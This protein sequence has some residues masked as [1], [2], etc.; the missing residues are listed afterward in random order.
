M[1]VVKLFFTTNAAAS[2][3]F[4]SLLFSEE[5]SLA[6]HLTF[7]RIGWFALEQKFGQFRQM[8]QSK[9]C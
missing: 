4:I 2:V 9:L 3:F 7:E 8:L 6:Y 1:G 5:P